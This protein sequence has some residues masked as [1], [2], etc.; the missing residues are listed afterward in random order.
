MKIFNSGKPEGRGDPG[1]PKLI[2]AD[3]IH[4]NINMLKAKNW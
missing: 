1:R 4:T 2:W 3:I